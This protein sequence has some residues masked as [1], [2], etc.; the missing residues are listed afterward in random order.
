MKSNLTKDTLQV[1]VV[2]L[3]VVAMVIGAIKLSKKLRSSNSGKVAVQFVYK[4]L[5]ECNEKLAAYGEDVEFDIPRHRATAEAL[6]EC[7]EKLGAYG[8]DITL[9]FIKE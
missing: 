7:M 5:N 6:N 3:V 9:P 8:E 2:S 1:I 4:Q